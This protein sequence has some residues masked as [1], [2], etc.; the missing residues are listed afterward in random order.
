MNISSRVCQLLGYESKADCK[1]V[2]KY[3]NMKSIYLND[4]IFK[5]DIVYSLS[6]NQG[7]GKMKRMKYL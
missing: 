3:W 1:A 7:L 6:C 4:F 5:F 2:F